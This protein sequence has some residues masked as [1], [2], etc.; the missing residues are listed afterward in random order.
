MPDDSG[1]DSLDLFRLSLGLPIGL[2]SPFGG[3]HNP[4][5]RL[6]LAWQGWLFCNGLPLRSNDYPDLFRIIG[7][8]YGAGYDPQ[9]GTHI[10]DFNLPDFRGRF[11]RGLDDEVSQR[12][13]DAHERV[14]M[15]PGGNSGRSVGSVQNYSTAYP[16]NGWTTQDAGSHS[17]TM[18]NSGEHD[19]DM[20]EAGEHRHQSGRDSGQP[21]GGEIALAGIRDRSTRHTNANVTSTNGEHRHDILPAGTHG[22]TIHSGGLHSH[23]VVGGDDESRPINAAVEWIIFVG[24]QSDL[25]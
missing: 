21:Q 16:R 9:S 19:H 8:A 11:L 15:N 3:P 25:R 6:R 14:A 20:R 4:E 7:T 2:V 12:D 1:D 10:G 13:P 18:A 24:R 22:H 5:N 17:H 23:R